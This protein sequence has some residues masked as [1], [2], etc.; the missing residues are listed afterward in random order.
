MRRFRITK[1]RESVVIGGIQMPL[2]AGTIISDSGHGREVVDRLLG[3]QGLETERLPDEVP[4]TGPA[5][6]ASELETQPGTSGGTVGPG[7]AAPVRER[8]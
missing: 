8:P 6:P 4:N 3:L 1:T 7:E 2:Y 5:E